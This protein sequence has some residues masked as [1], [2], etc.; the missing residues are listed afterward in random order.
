MKAN[1]DLMER[2]NQR[3]AKFIEEKNDEAPVHFPYN[4]G[5]AIEKQRKQMAEN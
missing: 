2:K 4:H 3:K 1:D 5:E